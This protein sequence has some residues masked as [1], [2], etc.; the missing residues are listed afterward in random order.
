MAC[1]DG[2][3]RAFY[4]EVLKVV[5]A[6]D[7]VIE[8]LDARDPIGC[9]CPELERLVLRGGV[10]GGPGGP[11]RLILLL[12]KIGEPP[13]ACSLTLAGCGSLTLQLGL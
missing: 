6:A 2:S 5:E 4:R 10:S 9:R 7:V 3:R 1:A 8:V 13:A 12:N 11:K